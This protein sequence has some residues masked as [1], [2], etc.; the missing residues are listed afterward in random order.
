MQQTTTSKTFFRIYR[1]HRDWC[2]EVREFT[3]DRE[4]KVDPQY[5]VTT[6]R[7]A[8]YEQAERAMVYYVRQALGLVGIQVG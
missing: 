4:S 5:F 8:N 7:Y 3:Y 1:E 6:Y 2:P